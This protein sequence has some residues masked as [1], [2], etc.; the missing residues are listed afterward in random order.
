[1][2][3]IKILKLLMCENDFGSLYCFDLN[4]RYKEFCNK[5]IHSDWL[6]EIILNRK[7]LN[8]ITN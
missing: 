3:F 1:M 6:N 8:F 2:C 5:N 7:L 4:T